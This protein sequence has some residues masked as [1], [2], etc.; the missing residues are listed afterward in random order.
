MTNKVSAVEDFKARKHGSGVWG[1][2]LH[3]ACR[4]S[5]VGVAKAKAV[6]NDGVKL[7]QKRDVQKKRVVSV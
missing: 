5:G 2:R 7:K 4:E 6:Q 3:S 1:G